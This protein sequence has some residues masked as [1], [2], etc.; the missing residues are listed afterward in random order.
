MI[1]CKEA[2]RYIDRRDFEKLSFREKMGLRFHNFMCK[3][4]RGYSKDS[5]IIRKLMGKIAKDN[6]CLS[7]EEKEE[8]K[9]KMAS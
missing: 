1:D 7:C 6:K 8:M 2:A 5:H 4:C 9:R 3:N